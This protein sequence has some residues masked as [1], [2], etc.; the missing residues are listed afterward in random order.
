[1]G[2]G[3][4]HE[5]A[6]TAA[7]GA[8]VDA[9][10]FVV[11]ERVDRRLHDRDHEATEQVAHGDEAA[12]IAAFGKRLDS[13]G[14]DRSTEHPVDLREHDLPRAFALIAPAALR[15]RAERRA[16]AS[17]LDERRRGT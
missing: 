10:Q 14:A 11:H 13:A 6:G 5:V 12:G 9:Q 8:L 7:V 17:C 15:E 16:H 1:V 3:E 2:A 4:V